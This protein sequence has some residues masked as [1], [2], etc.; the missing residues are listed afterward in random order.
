MKKI[1]LAAA[2]IGALC[3]TSAQAVDG[4][5]N[6]NGSVAA[7]CTFTTDSATINLGELAGANGTLDTSV[8]NGKNATLNGWCNGVASTMT[9]NAAP[10]AHTTVATAPAGFARRVDYTAT[11]SLSSASLATTVNGTDSSAGAL[12]AGTP[13]L[14]GLFSG[15][16]TVTLS[17]AAS[18]ENAGGIMVA[19]SYTGLVTVTLTPS[20]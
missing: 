15:P 1:L 16:I 9:V 17:A 4:T 6:I 13:V 14:A 10:I 11:A 20:A 3:V 8:V 18:A 2:A 7:K 19:G 12:A 5:V